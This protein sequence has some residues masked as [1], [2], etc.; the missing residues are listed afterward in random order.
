MVQTAKRSFPRTLDSARRAREWVKVICLGWQKDPNECDDLVL[1][2]SELVTNALL[3]GKGRIGVNLTHSA[4]SIRV[5]VSD[6]GHDP[7]NMGAPTTDGTTGRGLSIVDALSERWG[8]RKNSHG[9]V[10]VWADVT[11]T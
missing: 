1:I 6:A 7:I 4:Q 10:V 11:A 9:H 2:T 3:H 5:Q 8:T